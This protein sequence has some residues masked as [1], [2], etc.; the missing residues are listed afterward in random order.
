MTN[1]FADIPPFTEA[2]T[3]LPGC[4]AVTGRLGEALRAGASPD[5][6]LA[7]SNGAI[8]ITEGHSTIATAAPTHYQPQ[9]N[10]ANPMTDSIT[11]APCPTCGEPMAMS[12][13]VGYWCWVGNRVG[14]QKLGRSVAGCPE[15]ASEDPRVIAHMGQEA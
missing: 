12:P 11:S 6:T 4:W 15:I 7:V 3:V 14:L 5:L 10:E 1:P 8:S 9:P 2:E 13:S